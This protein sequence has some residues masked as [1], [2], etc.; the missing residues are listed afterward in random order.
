M[1]EPFSQ[2]LE[3]MVSRLSHVVKDWGMVR[4]GIIAY[5]WGLRIVVRGFVQAPNRGLRD[6]GHNIGIPAR[7]SNGPLREAF[8]FGVGYGLVRACVRMADEGPFA[9]GKGYGGVKGDAH[10]SPCAGL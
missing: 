3:R 6:G 2:E 8:F 1:G 5:G 4:L 9:R 10:L 7:G